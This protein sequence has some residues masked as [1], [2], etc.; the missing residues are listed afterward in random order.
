MVGLTC[1][2][3]YKTGLFSARPQHMLV[4]QL[5]SP[6]HV[7]YGETDRL[8]PPKFPNTRSSEKLLPFGG[9]LSKDTKHPCTEP[10]CI[11]SDLQSFTSS[12][13]ACLV[14]WLMLLRRCQSAVCFGK[15]AS[16]SAEVVRHPA[17]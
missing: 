1:E 3:A 15:L 9:A 4:Y 16:A 13:E 17:R 6:P 10:I 2:V 7:V 8:E 11:S 5:M 14:Y 12:V